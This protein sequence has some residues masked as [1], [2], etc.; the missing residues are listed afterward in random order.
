M[1]EVNRNQL[2]ASCVAV[3]LGL[4]T[5]GCGGGNSG[6]PTTQDNTDNQSSSTPEVTSSLSVTAEFEGEVPEPESVD[7]SANSECGKDTIKKQ[8]VK[9]TDGKL[10]DVVVTIEDGPSGYE[11]EARSL[12]IDQENCKYKPHVATAK[13]GQSVTVTNSDGGLH[14]VRGTR[15]GSQLFNLS[16][17]KGDKK[18]VSFDESGPVKL[19]CNVHPWMSAFV[20]VTESG[21]A[22][23]TGEDGTATL[24]QLPPGD[25]TITTWHEEYGSST[26]DITVSEEEEASLTVTFPSS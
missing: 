22:S 12:T 21:N 23:I 26:H 24:S 3:F 5:V 14:N 17:F 25:Y 6:T 1:I 9:V 13:V 10:Q 19:E 7:A 8:S 16:T 20:Y 11:K 4:F 15:D 18:D 2:L